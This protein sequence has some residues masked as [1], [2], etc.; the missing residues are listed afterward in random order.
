MARR[1]ADRRSDGKRAGNEIEGIIRKNYGS[2]NVDR[3][4]NLIKDNRRELPH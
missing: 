1:R 2:M 4:W 3:F